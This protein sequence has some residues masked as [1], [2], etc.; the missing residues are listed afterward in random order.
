MRFKKYYVN[1]FKGLEFQDYYGQICSLQKSSLAGPEAIWLGL[2]NTG[3]NMGRDES[4]KST[5]YKDVNARMHL[6]QAQVKK[7]LPHIIKFAET[8]E[9]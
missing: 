9:L 8:G 7:L 2:S 5:P 1:G 4:G 3:P 6:S